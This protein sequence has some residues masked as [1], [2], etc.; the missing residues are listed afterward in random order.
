[1]SGKKKRK[2]LRGTVQKVLKPVVPNEPEKAQIVVEEAD[3][4]YREIRVENVLTDEDGEKVRLKPGA[5]VDVVV[6][7]DTDATT[8]K[9]E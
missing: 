4:L 5:D 9:T 8:K 2:K 1:M 7:A 6:E 3:E